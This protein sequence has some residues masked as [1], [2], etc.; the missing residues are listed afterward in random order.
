MPYRAPT[1]TKGKKHINENVNIRIDN[2]IFGTNS[3]RMD[4]TIQRDFKK[5][6]RERSENRIDDKL[7]VVIV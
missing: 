3:S 2:D 6:A 1:N 5:T 4:F 7:R